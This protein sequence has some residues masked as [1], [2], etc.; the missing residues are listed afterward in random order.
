MKK[1]AGKVKREKK[2]SFLLQEISNLI[3]QIA[4]DDPRIKSI[5]VTKI[6]LSKSGG[7]CYVYFS[8]Y[9][10]NYDPKEYL[11]VL[12]LYKPSVRTAM[13]KILQSKYIPD[14]RFTHDEGKDKERRIHALLDEISQEG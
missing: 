4:A 10:S 3:R 13:S 11:E 12:K 1:V 7:I 5:F 14:I 2:K 9:D 8:S 6:E